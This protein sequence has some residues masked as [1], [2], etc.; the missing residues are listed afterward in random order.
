MLRKNILANLNNIKNKL[1]ER[2]S[3]LPTKV[4]GNRGYKDNNGIPLDIL[5]NVTRGNQ[6]ATQVGDTLKF[7]SANNHGT[8]DAYDQD[9]NGV[10]ITYGK[11]GMVWFNADAFIKL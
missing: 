3:L 6:A 11:Y 2:D 4:S 7:N 9:S 8:I 5:D 1:S 10:G